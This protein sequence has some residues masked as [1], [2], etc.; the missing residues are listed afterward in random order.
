MALSEL[1][2]KSKFAIIV[3]LVTFCGTSFFM[4]GDREIVTMKETRDKCVKCAG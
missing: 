1:T 4:V 3:G 2:V